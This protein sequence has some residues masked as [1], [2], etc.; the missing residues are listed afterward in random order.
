MKSNTINKPG[1]VRYLLV[2]VLLMVS[3]DDLTGENQ[4]P[5]LGW[6]INDSM[7]AIHEMLL[8]G[9]CVPR[10]I[11][12]KYKFEL[13][14]VE[15]TCGDLTEQWEEKLYKPFFGGEEFGVGFFFYD[16]IRAENVR[17][18][19]RY[20]LPRI[21]PLYGTMSAVTYQNVSSGEMTFETYRYENPNSPY[22]IHATVVYDLATDKLNIRA[23]TIFNDIDTSSSWPDFYPEGACTETYNIKATLIE[24]CPA[25][26]RAWSDVTEEY[27]AAP[28]EHPDDEYI[29]LEYKCDCICRYCNLP[30]RVPPY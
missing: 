18:E 16:D 30:G 2:V 7:C 5:E 29:P 21:T 13:E 19:I 4:T 11:Q 22:T 6:E 28:E 1:Q 9:K 3:C 20:P 17:I 23:K 12:G 27:R 24:E 25:G 15:S 8:D 14:S 10:P 26:C